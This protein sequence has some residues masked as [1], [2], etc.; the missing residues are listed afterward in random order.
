MDNVVSILKVPGLNHL[1]KAAILKYIQNWALAFEGKASLSYVGQVYAMLK[2]EGLL[3]CQISL[4][5]SLTQ[6]YH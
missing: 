5:P 4:Y 6:S 2:T 1:V 3:L